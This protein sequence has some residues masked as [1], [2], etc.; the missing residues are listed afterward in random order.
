MICKSFPHTLTRLLL[1][2][3]SN[4]TTRKK[5]LLSYAHSTSKDVTFVTAH[6]CKHAKCALL[7]SFPGGVQVA[8]T[9]LPL[10]RLMDCGKSL[11][12]KPQPES[13]KSYF[14]DITGGIKFCSK[15]VNQ[16]RQQPT[17]EKLIIKHANLKKLS[18]WGC[19]AVDV[20]CQIRDGTHLYFGF[21]T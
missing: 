15:V 12:V 1:A 10:L 8:A 17:Y 16:K 19:S 7:I 13:G 11:C 2:L 20:S 21:L 4:I 6:T 14:G 5:K 3:C 9:Q 18:L